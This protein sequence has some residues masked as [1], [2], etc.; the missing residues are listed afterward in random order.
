MS[1][2]AGIIYF[3]GAPVNPGLIAAMTA[4]MSCR[5]PDGIHHWIGDSV[6]LG[7]C[8]LHATPE[9]SEEHQPLSDAG[10]NLVLVLDGR[11]DNRQELQR[12]L[13]GKGRV[14]RNDTDAELVLGSY[15]IWG[16]DSPSHL[17]GDFAFVVWDGHRRK[18]FGARD[19]FGVKPFYYYSGTRYFAFASD[20]EALL[21]LPGVSH[22]P[23]EDRVASVLVPQFEPAGL[24]QSWLKDIAKLPPGSMLTVERLG[25]RTIRPY[26]QLE[27]QE[28]MNGIP[29]TG[30]EEAFLSIFGEAVRCRMRTRWHPALML[31]G[32]MDSASIAGMARS[33][34][35]GMP[36]LELH[37]F[38]AVSDNPAECPETRNIQAVVKGYE[39]YAHRVSLPGLQGI[40]TG[41]DL[42]EA[43]LANAHP[44]GNSILLPAMMYL[45]AAR[46]GHRVMHDGIDGDLTT[47]TPTRYMGGL[48]RSGEW[49]RAW[50]ESRRA[51]V[52]N[53]YLRSLSPMVIFLKSVWDVVAPL[54]LKLFRQSISR[55]GQGRT[56]GHSLINRDFAADIRLAARLE[57]WQAET[58]AIA[59]Q[60]GQREH[61]HALTQ[62]GI[63]RGMEGFDRV[64]ARYGVEP[65]HP[66]VDRRLVEWYLR[67]P[68][69]QKARDGWTKYLLRSAMAPWLDAEIRWHQR[70]DHL[71]WRFVDHLMEK[72]REQVRSALESAGAAIGKYADPRS[73]QDL[74][75]RYDAGP[76]A[77]DRDQVFMVMT[78]TLWLERLRL[79]SVRKRDNAGASVR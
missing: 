46:S 15:C 11:L 25:S 33:I 74:L 35:P 62:P 77:A 68:L 2:I 75:R 52:N 14:L 58:L 36:Q 53:T 69:R 26:W 4:A 38:S 6:A 65:R 63:T 51:S 17:L 47:F 3:D 29:D 7:H 23:D 28:E 43:A 22:E 21:G 34:L 10:E 16:E 56:F 78:L 41:Q 9:S 13:R 24:G 76:N 60:G 48:L 31:S 12:E 45:A 32:G 54:R 72:N 49:R 50:T 57:K 20:E 61:I 30:Y 70:K 39:R 55:M 66:W 79:A 18:I 67:L 27:P 73:L 19:H 44:V 5:G 42:A 59:H 37:T 40:V 1:G 71:G 64:A 8:M